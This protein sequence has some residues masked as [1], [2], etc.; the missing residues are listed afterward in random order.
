VSFC[1]Y[2]VLFIFLNVHYSS[3]SGT[4]DNRISELKSS[5]SSTLV[6]TTAGKYEQQQQSVVVRTT[7]TVISSTTSGTVTNETTTVN[8]TSHTPDSEFYEFLCLLYS[9]V[10]LRQVMIAVTVPL[11]FWG[12]IAHR[13]KEQQITPRDHVERKFNT[14]MRI[15]HMVSMSHYVDYES[16]S[17]LS[18]PVGNLWTSCCQN[19]TYN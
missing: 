8:S 14:R 12:N 17:Q 19:H 16:W 4:E 10:Y 1:H 13:C 3:T 5:A 18:C 6:T 15:P 9:V 7:T 2:C 11:I